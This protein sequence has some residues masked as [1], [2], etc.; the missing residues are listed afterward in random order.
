M[1]IYQ[2]FTLIELVIVVA[3]V[4]ILTAIG[5]PSYRDYV[6]RTNRVEAKTALATLT[7]AQE[8]FYSVNNRYAANVASLG[9]AAGLTAQGSLWA[10][11]NGYYTI[12]M[13]NV[14]GQATIAAGGPY[15]LRATPTLKGGQSDDKCNQ[16][17]LNS[18]GKKDIASAY[19]G[20]V[21]QDCW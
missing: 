9:A 17:T 2:G 6:V 1:R 10:T 16:L 7:M 5:L 19:S 18:A 15:L 13:E 12:S 20:K 21:W 3:I 4:G 11:P 14:P 8:R